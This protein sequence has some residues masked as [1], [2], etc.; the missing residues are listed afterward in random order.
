MVRIVVHRFGNPKE[1][2]VGKALEIMNNCYRHIGVHA[3]EIVG[4]YL[5]DKSSAMNALINEE[6][7]NLGIGTSAFEESFFAV[8]D[9]WRGTPRIMV[10][11]D[12]MLALPR[13]VR[14]GGLHHEVA[15]TVLHGSLE[16]Y[17]FSFPISLLRLERK[18]IVS[19]QSM[20]D[21]LHLAS[22]A[23]KDYEVTRL[24]YKNGFVEDQV[25]YN[26]YFLEPSEEDREAWKL[27]R[28]NKIARLLVLVSLLKT[29]CCA[30]P[31]LKDERYRGDIAESIARSM[32]YLPEGLSASLLKMLEEAPKLSENT[33]E[34]VDLFMKKIVEDLF[35][36]TD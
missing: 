32:S 11:F 28:N 22:I 34:N 10:A 24:L 36:N 25:A 3:V 30:A 5:F 26:R 9:A 14:I 31:L 33:H 27:A 29:A 16:Y 13:L 7:R 19:R 17:S 6:K 18:G 21:I 1:R 4:I 2:F 23:V 20:Q 15:H 8:H 35:G 12:K